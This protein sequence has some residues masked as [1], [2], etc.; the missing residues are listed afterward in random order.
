M[1]ICNEKVNVDDAFLIFLV[2]FIFRY[3]MGLAL[4][5]D[6][7]ETLFGVFC[8]CSLKFEYD[9]R[10]KSTGLS[11]SASRTAFLF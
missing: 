3:F 5:V 7:N 1:K 9:L 8:L 6:M 11:V 10:S 4:Q 2:F